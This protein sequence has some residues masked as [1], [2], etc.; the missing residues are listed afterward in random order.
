MI[1]VPASALPPTAEN[2]RNTGCQELRQPL[3]PGDA[4]LVPDPDDLRPFLFPSVHALAVDDAGIRFV[5]RE[6]IPTFNPST[7]VPA[8]LAALAPAIRS[9]MVARDRARATNKLKQIGIAFHNFLEM[10]G[11]FPADIRGKDAKPVLSWRVAILPF[12]EQG[13]LCKE[14]HQN[15]PWDSPHNKALVARMPP[16]FA[17]PHADESE[18]GQTF[19]RGF[20]G[21]GA[22]FDP[23]AAEGVAV[24]HITDGTSNT[25]HL[26]E[27][28]ESVP[29]TK[30]GSDL[31]FD[32]DPNP[33]PEK[34][35]GDPRSWAGMRSGVSTC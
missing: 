29:W 35:K 33:I 4:E 22:M 10:N 28:R 15:E 3:P 9:A 2:G 24:A 21:A 19:Y 34:L 26:V 30:P 18:V 13:E 6:A 20:S 17:D 16:V 12:L 11:H 7:V 25:I 8:G 5:S 14:F 32:N 31:A 1:Q 23:K 27:A